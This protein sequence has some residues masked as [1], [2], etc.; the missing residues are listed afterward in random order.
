M[1]QSKQQRRATRQRKRGRDRSHRQEWIGQPTGDVAYQWS[2]AVFRHAADIPAAQCVGALAASPVGLVDAAGAA[3]TRD[4]LGALVDSGWTPND[5]AEIGRRR[6]NEP[7]RRYLR[8]FDGPQCEGAQPYLS[9]WAGQHDLPREEALGAILEMLVTLSNLPPMAQTGTH[10]AHHVDSV[11]ERMLAK[12]RALLAKAEST[13]FEAEAEALTGA[14]QKLMSRYAL[15]AATVE[16][17]KGTAQ[18]ADVR[19]IWLD[20]PYVRAKSALVSAVG[21]ANRCRTVLMEQVG[22]VTVIGSATDLR[23][24]ELLSTSLLLQATR[25][26]VAFGGQRSRSGVSQTRS[27]RQSFLVAY[28]QRIGERLVQADQSARAETDDP[29]LLPVLAAR[30]RSVDEKL[31][32]LFPDTSALDVAIS[33]GAGWAAGRAAAELALFDVGPLLETAQAG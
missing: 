27:F 17:D 29:R 30:S 16:H 8:S 1:K 3:I 7:A 32:A 10:S 5:L 11:E 14:A 26:M 20:A 21:R 33:N 6:L 28:G 25:A 4:I 23:T 12:V 22:F 9:Q 13:E 2:L 19:R 24:V 31:E 15:D 18:Q